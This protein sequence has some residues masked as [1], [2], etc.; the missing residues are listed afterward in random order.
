MTPSLTVK[1]LPLLGML[2]AMQV[3]LGSLLTIQLLLTKISFTFIIIALTARLFSPPV[4]AGSAAFANLLGMLLFPKFTFFP[5]FILTAF[6]TGLV[7]GLA[8]QQ[9]T[10]LPRIL[11]ANFIVVFILN[12]FMNSLWLHIMYMTPWS[13]L[14]TTRLIQEIVTYV[15][16]TVIL[17]AVFK[18]PILT[19][20]TTRDSGH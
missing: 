6:L 15:C 1:R 14:L 13:V 18:V 4:T 12:L 11:T 16:Y 17:I 19:K 20:L 7:F 5:G 3:V 2:V 9:Q 8:F 10:N